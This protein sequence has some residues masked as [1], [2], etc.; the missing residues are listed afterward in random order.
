MSGPP[1]PSSH[2]SYTQR[3]T[4]QGW[5]VVQTPEDSR[6]G[7]SLGVN[8]PGPSICPIFSSSTPVTAFP[9]PF[10]SEHFLSGLGD[11][12]RNASVSSFG[13][14]DSAGS[15][16][17]QNSGQG[18]SAP[19]VASSVGS[20]GGR[21]VSRPLGALRTSTSVP[22]FFQSKR[23]SLLKKKTLSSGERLSREGAFWGGDLFETEED[24][25]Q[26]PCSP[27]TS[28]LLSAATLNR[29]TSHSSGL[30]S[31]VC[32]LPGN[33]AKGGSGSLQRGPSPSSTPL[34]QSAPASSSSSWKSS[35]F[36][37]KQSGKLVGLGGELG[38]SCPD[39]VA[40]EAAAS[41]LGG[42]RTES[43][44]HTPSS[45]E[46]D[47]TSFPDS[48]STEES[49]PA[50]TLAGLVPPTGLSYEGGMGMRSRFSQV[51]SYP[52]FSSFQQSGFTTTSPPPSLSRIQASE[53]EQSP[54]AQYPGKVELPSSMWAHRP[55]R[56]RVSRS[57]ESQASASLSSK[58]PA[59]WT[60]PQKH[61]APFS[62]L[63]RRLSI[64]KLRP[65][66][67][68]PRGVSSGSGEGVGGGGVL[69]QDSNESDYGNFDKNALRVGDIS[70]VPE[71]VP[72]QVDSAYSN[73]TGGSDVSSDG[74]STSKLADIPAPSFHVAPRGASP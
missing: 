37:R 19:S 24:S 33:S 18:D 43:E 52:S 13:R 59:P 17:S 14:H 70:A 48:V 55:S 26:T 12:H 67:S 27:R 53:L 61:N 15:G 29:S 1:P 39:L 20:G 74:E 71:E 23:V 56:G 50:V 69:R 16:L 60:P 45:I 47:L 4:P 41:P 3:H 22:N 57:S 44:A 32:A 49:Y 73:S 10:C 5:A 28:G 9:H 62:G 2:N 21:K 51:K 31:A 8:S 46:K 30:P 42:S 35:F 11:S 7:P 40:L 36:S 54:L 58:A 6:E 72:A 65:A 66:A 25:A 64:R 68:S 63:S 34:T 38:G